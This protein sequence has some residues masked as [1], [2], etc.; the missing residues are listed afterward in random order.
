MKCPECDSDIFN[1]LSHGQTMMGSDFGCED[2]R[3]RHPHDPNAHT[4]VYE[5]ENGH[6]FSVYHYVRCYACGWR[7]TTR[8]SHQ[9]W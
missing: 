8:R 9:P 5:C 6:T 3:G 1:E 2:A 7:P 4:R